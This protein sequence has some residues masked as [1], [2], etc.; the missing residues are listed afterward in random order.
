MAQPSN[1]P[2]E[3]YE[4]HGGI[5]SVVTKVGIIVQTHD[6][7]ALWVIKPNHLLP[8]NNLSPVVYG[9]IL[10]L[11]INGEPSHNNFMYAKLNVSTRQLTIGQSPFAPNE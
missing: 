5:P 9:N 6:G 3:T 8:G 7:T 1:S 4:I 11:T 2:N 10:C